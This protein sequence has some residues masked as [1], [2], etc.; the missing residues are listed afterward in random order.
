MA[1]HHPKLAAL[2]KSIS[3]RKGELA[4]LEKREDELLQALEAVRRE[5]G[6]V[7][8]GIQQLNALIEAFEIDPDEVRGIRATPRK[9]GSAHGAFRGTLV[10]ILKEAGGPITTATILDVLRE[11]NDSRINLPESTRDA[12]D[13][14]GRDIRAIS[15]YGVVIRHDSGARGQP[16]TWRWI[17]QN[18]E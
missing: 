14:I 15:T 1:N 18:Q 5:K 11:L 3:Y 6:D 10:K 9:S 13:K 8:Q 4:S 2:A 16:A 12:L 17:G 7:E